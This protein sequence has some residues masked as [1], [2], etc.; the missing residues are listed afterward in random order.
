M[1]K[2]SGFLKQN[3]CRYR[4]LSLIFLLG[5]LLGN[6]LYAEEVNSNLNITFKANSDS[7]TLELPDARVI[8]KKKN[9]TAE[10]IKSDFVRKIPSTLN[11]PLRVIAFT[12]GVT[13]QN[14][15]NVR[16]FIRGGD[17]EQTEVVMNGIALLQPYHVGGVFS[18][19]NLSTL[20]SVELYRDDFPVEYPGVL[21]GVVNLKNKNPF[22]SESHVN[23]NIS[24]V[25]GDAFAELPIIK[26]QLSVYGAAQ[27]FLFNRSLRGLLNA[28]SA[29]SSDSTFQEDIQGYREHINLPEFQDYHWGAAYAVND[30][31]HFHYNGN[32]SL[33]DYAV[34]IPRQANILHGLSPGPSSPP[35][36]PEKEIKRTQKL[37][38]DSVSAVNINNQ[39]HLWNMSWDINSQHFLE[40][41]FG[42][43]S[44]NWDVGFKKGAGVTAYSNKPLALSEA[45]RIF[46]YQLVD[47]YT[48]SESNQLKW[49]LSYD[50][51]QQKYNAEL[52][53]VLY[54]VVVNSNIDM[55]AD[56][57]SF[58]PSGFTIEKDDS[59]K[60]N[61]D[62]L[63]DYPARIRFSHSG[64]L[65]DHFAS[66]FFSQTLK[67]SSG[68]LSYGLRGEY[69]NRTQEFFP[70]PRLSYRW[71]VDPKNEL[72][73]NSG[74]YSQN[75]L[76][77][78]Q[79]D[80]NNN[81]QSE[82]SAQVGLQWS[83]EFSK[84]YRLVVDNYYKYYYDLVS[85]NL[86]PNNTIDLQS[87]LLPMPR[88]KLSASEL[89]N[90]K[91]VLDTTKNFSGLSDSI[92][93]LA[94]ANFGGLNFAYN[95]SG[96]GNS[97]GTELAFYYDPT[98]VWS[99]WASVDLSFSNRQDVSDQ[100]YYAFANHRP[101]ILNWV[102]TFTMPSNYSLSFTYRWAMGQSYTPYSGTS[103][104][105][106][107]QPIIVGARNAGRLSPYS[108]LDMRL[109]HNTHWRNSNFKAYI[110][111][112]NAMNNPNY[113]A[114][115][116]ET[117]QLKSAQLNWPF[118]LLFLGLNWE[119]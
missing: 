17:A 104:D 86:V 108:R 24:L 105:K 103:E 3:Q 112:W 4:Y 95:N 90:L 102:N 22:E 87:L 56:L 84:G 97:V 32:F 85:S 33:D 18:I 72:V 39:M 94:Y 50:Y 73:F 113:F 57:G 92:Q 58:S 59:S 2:V 20:E 34:L 70:A 65:T 19:F 60:S 53:Y 117:G 48:L 46:N 100:P 71:N 35:L 6:D 16:P 101:L 30:N 116:K 15:L 54:D 8:A 67:T 110:E 9:Q 76:P 77:Y 7:L 12:P 25:R 47:H 99:G 11:D 91:S 81:L 1:P 40:N 79:R 23:A 82:K 55:L 5:I 43:Q 64:E 13:V 63:G 68:S 119:I 37:S 107:L 69:Q 42:F 74:L 36:V 96:K 41:N 14:D 28:S 114:R 45:T 21:S 44:Q 52:P 109:A 27:A 31:L 62:Y 118:P 49:G 106:N 78:Y 10:S 115:D 51:K 26:N 98:N 93:Q 38:V 111:I 66:L 88:S 83:H 80:E 61:L 29:A 89:Q 75:N